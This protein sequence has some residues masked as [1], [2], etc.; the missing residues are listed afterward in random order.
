MIPSLPDE[1]MEAVRRDAKRC[2]DVIP[3]PT[4]LVP[5]FY[6]KM[7][8]AY[9]YS[10]SQ[11]AHIGADVYTKWCVYRWLDTKV[12]AVAKADY[13]IDLVDLF[14]PLLRVKGKTKYPQ[15][16]KKRVLHVV[17]VE[18]QAD[19]TLAQEFETMCKLGVA[20]PERIIASGATH[21]LYKAWKRVRSCYP[22]VD[23]HWTDG[24]W[25]MTH[26]PAVPMLVCTK[27]QDEQD[28]DNDE[29]GG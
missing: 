2:L 22:L 25:H 26:D 15:K 29:D 14:A 12:P 10:T 19:E 4:A 13:Y 18:A 23:A 11:D 24:S 27:R 8:W 6:A 21:L 7:E 1:V 17:L 9:E 20:T 5:E 16:G 28:A 3:L